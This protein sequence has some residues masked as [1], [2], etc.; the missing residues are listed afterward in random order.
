MIIKEVLQ[1]FICETSFFD[2]FC[3][4][5]N[6]RMASLSSIAYIRHEADIE[7]AIFKNKVKWCLIGKRGNLHKGF[8]FFYS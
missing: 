7:A 4:M 2:I 5:L 3:D 6:S 8:L 1:E